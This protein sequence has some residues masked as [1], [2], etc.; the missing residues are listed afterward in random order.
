MTQR[1]FCSLAARLMRQPAAPYHEHA[2][3]REVKKVCSEHGLHWYEDK[4][5]NLLVRIDNK[6]ISGSRK[7][8]PI[9]FAAHMD[10][11]GFEM[12]PDAKSPRVRFLGGVPDEYFRPGLRLRLM[13]AGLKAKLGKRLGKE[14][15]FELR[16]TERMPGKNRF[17]VWDLEDFAV[18]KGFIHGRS[19]DDLIGVASALAALIDLK[20]SVRHA[21]G[22]APA[23]SPFTPIAAIS[24]AEEVGFHGALAM[25]GSTSIPKNALV[26]SLETSRELPGVKMG[27]GVILRV[28]DRTSIF[29]SD[30]MRFL[31][32][33]AAQRASERR[34]PILRFAYQ[35]ALMSGGTCEATAYQEYGYQTAAVCIALGNYHNCGLQK[36]IAP[37]YVNIADALSMVDLLVSAA[38]GMCRF[39]EIIQTLPTRLEKMRKEAA[40][41]LAATKSLS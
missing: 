4:F 40:P 26:I 13:P 27:N 32:G 21:G 38:K 16:S 3:V 8:R 1:E 19:C 31:S 28:G 14:R 23:T 35:R 36:R 33:V 25:C 34:S 30:A 5:G 9:V 24:R 41:K 11:P 22:C 2:V 20:R 6:K 29:N 39:N 7:V 37:E 12:I 15:L 18:K 17:A 10:H